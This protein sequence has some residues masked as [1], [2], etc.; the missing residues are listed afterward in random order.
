[1]CTIKKKC[2]KALVIKH[3]QSLILKCSLDLQQNFS[4]P[5][6]GRFFFLKKIRLNSVS[7]MG[8]SLSQNFCF[9]LPLQQEGLVSDLPL[10]CLSMCACACVAEDTPQT[11]LM[12]PKS[13]C[14][15]NAIQ[16]RW[17]LHLEVVQLICY[18]TQVLKYIA[19]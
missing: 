11:L 5:N 7:M 6:P 4:N 3:N 8:I 10:P 19:L 14:C 18:H 12:S 16:W 1:M 2:H 9:Q 13:S 17:R 15:K